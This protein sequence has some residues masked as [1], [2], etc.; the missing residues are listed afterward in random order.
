MKTISEIRVEIGSLE[1][2]IKTNELK[3]AQVTRLK[4]KI[5]YLR[6]IILYLETNPSEEF[7]KSEINK[8]EEK[9]KRRQNEIPGSAFGKELRAIEKDLGI[10]HLR[11]QVSTM[12]YILS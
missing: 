11:E 5:V 8:N 12:H 9:I 7:L 4:N 2:T 1:D 10:I 6:S 3:P